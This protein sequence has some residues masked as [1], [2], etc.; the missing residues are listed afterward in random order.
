LTDLVVQALLA[1]T[2]VRSLQVRLAIT[3][4]NLASLKATLQ[5]SQWRLQAGQVTSLVIEQ[6]RTA[7]AQTATQIPALEAS[8]SQL[9]HALAVLTGHLPDALKD[10]LTDVRPV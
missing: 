9:R 8:L 6:S 3:R 10:A 1:H 5:I 7:T 4:N 2:S